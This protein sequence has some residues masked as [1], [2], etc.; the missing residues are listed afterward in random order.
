VTSGGS[1]TGHSEDASSAS[2]LEASARNAWDRAASAVPRSAR[3]PPIDPSDARA[4]ATRRWRFADANGADDEA[5]T[6][7]AAAAGIV[8]PLDRAPRADPDDACVRID[9]GVIA[10]TMAC[11]ARRR[12][13]RG[14]PMPLAHELYRSHSNPTTR[15]TWTRFSLRRRSAPQKGGFPGLQCSR[16]PTRLVATSSARFLS[17]Q[18]TLFAFVYYKVYARDR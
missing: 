8:D 13:A 6:D 5:R 7:D 16:V 18:N 9:A 2:S 17:S 12:R 14:R 1:H 4:R 15:F 10:N 3:A 11:A